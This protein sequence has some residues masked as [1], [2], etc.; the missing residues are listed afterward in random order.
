[1]ITTTDKSAY[2]HD[3]SNPTPEEARRG[4]NAQTQGGG[5]M[6]TPTRPPWSMEFQSSFLGQSPEEVAD[7]VSK[8]LSGTILETEYCAI[9]D[10]KSVQDRSALLVRA[11]GHQDGDEPKFVTVR[12]PFEE[13]NAALG[14]YS[15]GEL[16]PEEHLANGAPSR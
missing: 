15:I 8:E 3:E 1:M 7:F 14:C 11:G 6:K 10:E 4:V 9:I 12:Q 2:Q 5:P 13:I 16:D